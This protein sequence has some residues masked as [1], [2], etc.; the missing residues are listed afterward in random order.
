MKELIALHANTGELGGDLKHDTVAIIG[1]T[2]DLQEKVRFPA[3]YFA[4]CLTRGMRCGQVVRQAMTPIDSV[5]MLPLDTKLDHDTMQRIYDSG[6]SRVPVYEE[7]DVPVVSEAEAGNALTNTED[8]PL[9]TKRARKIVGILLVKQVRPLSTLRQAFQ[10]TE[11]KQVLDARSQR[12]AAR[13]ELISI[14]RAFLTRCSRCNSLA[15]ASLAESLLYSEQ[16]AAVGS[17]GSFPGRPFPYGHR[18]TL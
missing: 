15:D 3:E 12:S 10:L 18:R 5:F 11:I 6:H 9:K 2:L 7:I 13:V 16:L 17:L 4:I 14:H 8:L 1:A